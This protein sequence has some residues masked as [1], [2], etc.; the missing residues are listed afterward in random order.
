MAVD[1]DDHGLIIWFTSE[2]NRTR[3]A[4]LELK[5]APKFQAKYQITG[6]GTAAPA[7]LFTGCPIA[8]HGFPLIAV[9]NA[10][11]CKCDHA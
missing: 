1:S 6:I 10:S 4:R 11:Q 3:L 8:K 5:L 2:E 9:T 7:Y